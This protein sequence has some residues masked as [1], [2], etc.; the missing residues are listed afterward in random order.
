[1]TWEELK[2]TIELGSIL[3]CRVK[4]KNTQFEEIIVDCYGFDGILKIEDISINLPLGKELFRAIRKDDSF[5]AVV[6]GFDDLK[7]KVILNTKVFRTN[8]EDILPFYTCKNLIEKNRQTHL[9]I[10]IKFLK[11]HRNILD[12]LRG[13]LSSNELTFLYELIQNAVDHPNKNFN[14]VSITFEVFN[15]YLLVKHNGALFT[16]NNFES[17]IGTLYGE[18]IQ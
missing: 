9:G 13:D 1:M 15:N 12:R 2:K 4:Y 10:D 18:Q 3:P 5:N 11:S 8:L 16:D 6:V 7:Q 17:I 14:N